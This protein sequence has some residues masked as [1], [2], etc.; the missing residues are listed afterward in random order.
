[1]IATY[2]ADFETTVFE[3][4]TFTEVWA[5]AW[6]RLGSEIV[7]IGNNI[8]DFFNDMI[9][10][11]FDK[12]I[13][14]FF[15]N[16]KFDG[17]FLLNFMMS[18]DNFK[19]AT[20]QDRHGDWH[21]KK[22]GELKNGEF[23]YMV[24][25]MGQWYEITLKWHGHLIKFRDS[26]KLLPFSVAKIGKDFGT[27]H[28]KTSIEYTGERYAGGVIT[29][30]EKQYI[31]NDV[32]VMSEALQIFFGLAENKATI[33]ACCIH[34]YRKMTKKEEWE[35]NFPDLY[36][37][38]IDPK[39]FGAKNADQ[40]IRKSYKGG[41]VYVVE[42]KEN[43]VFTDGVTADVNSLYPS[44]M[45]SQSGNFYPVGYPH[46]YQ[47]DSIPEQYLDKTKYYYFLR[48]RTRFYL[49]QGKL[50]FIVINGSWRYPSRTPLKSSDVLD[51]NGRYCE[52]IRT[53][54]GE[55]ED[56][57]VVLTLTCTEWELLQEHYNLIDCQILDYCVFRAEIGIFDKYIDKYSKIKKESKGAKR[58]V[59]KL[60]LNNLYGKM[61]QST[62]SSFK[63]AKLV[64]GVLKFT[65]QKADDR[66]PMYIPIGSAITSY[67]R[68]FT[69]RAAQKNFHG[70]GEHGFIYA[71]TD[72]I[73]CDLAPDEV[74]GIEIHAVNFCCWKLENCW[75]KAIFVRAK[76]YIE[77]TTHE[78]GEKVEPYY[79]IKC[80]GMSKGAKENFNNML[81]SG[82][83]RLT[84]FKVGL[85][86]GGKLLPRQIKGGTL[87]VNTTF[88]IHTKKQEK[89]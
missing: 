10:Q 1:M 80:A 34:D 83:A 85:E 82:K 32:L 65:I 58:Q 64:D 67:S 14:V 27:K 42:G 4:Q 50:P 60:F 13:V 39:I 3:G 9:C 78:D 24:S 47:G 29:D 38:P 61:A 57:S 15:H 76:T 52:Y 46:F 37:E 35:A 74:Q 20:Y 89:R 22:S 7:T 6:C 73:H 88:K 84:D 21:F 75:D 33:G 72:S 28:Q 30:E 45:S 53:E 87:L 26:L 81:I 25:D 23:T 66:K 31:A 16:L 56:T 71:D 70:A 5:Y 8:Y 17:S 63:I 79:L 18:Q 55:I 2:M 69:I 19:Q 48:I 40:Y 44:M 36:D 86:V 43:K 54:S 68:A 59:A 11:A 62:N 41:W 77:H 51:E 12:N 49:K